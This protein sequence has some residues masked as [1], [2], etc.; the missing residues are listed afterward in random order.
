MFD[1]KRNRKSELIL[2]INFNFNLW[3]SLH[4]IF[5]FLN[6]V[7]S[8]KI[9]YVIPMGLGLGFG[10]SLV[11]LS[12]PD[13]SYAN[14]LVNNSSKSVI[15]KKLILE[16]DNLSFNIKSS[17]TLNLLSNLQTEDVTQLQNNQ[18]ITVKNLPELSLGQVIK[19]VGQNNG[20]YEFRVIETKLINSNE[21]QTLLAENKNNLILFSQNNLIGS[22]L[23]AT[24]AK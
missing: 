4:K 21:Y 16:Q 6:F 11:I 19:L 7:F 22:K 17:Q 1:L 15:Y 13:L 14:N 12:N 23:L 10:L 9:F 3:Q 24:I 20:L 5:E 2:K 8:K 18:I